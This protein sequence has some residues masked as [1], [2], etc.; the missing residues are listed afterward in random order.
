LPRDHPSVRELALSVAG[1]LD[2]SEARAD[3]VERFLQE[4][5]TYALS[6]GVRIHNADPVAWFLLEARE[7]H[8]EFF[9]GAM[10]V[11]LRHLEV[12]ARMVAGYS[13]GDVSPDGDELVI[14]ESN[15]HAWVEVWLGA[16]RGWVAFDPTPP[17]GVPGLGGVSGL[18]RVRWV[19]QQLELMWDRRL[20]TFGLGE[21]I[22]LVDGLVDAY[23]RMTRMIDRKA[24]IV[25]GGVAV[26]A[27]AAVVLLWRLWRWRLRSWR[28]G[29]RRT[30]GPASRAVG[31]LARALIPV[32]GVAPPWATVRAIGRQA[33][34]F[35]PQSASAVDELVEHAEDELYGID[36][37][38][39][40][41]PAEIRRLWKRIRSGMKN[42][43]LTVDASCDA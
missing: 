10:V 28:M 25:G 18:E 27:A 23:H 22:D 6:S 39:N 13:G 15:A 29:S 40:G 36:G 20:L 19:W 32:G 16:D 12:P 9:A 1:D 17:V 34:S 5:F 7:G 42:R 26:M 24:I 30:H 38:R 2:S 8:C 4:N 35:W 3:A 37:D 14:R 11:M 43:E 31:R 33:A 41:D 21:Q